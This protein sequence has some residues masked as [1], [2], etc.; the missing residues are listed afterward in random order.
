MA[1][2]PR[3]S[4]LFIYALLIAVPVVS[5]VGAVALNVATSLET[6]W[7]FGLESVRQRPWAA[8]ALTTFGCIVGG[9]LLHRAE[10]RRALYADEPPPPAAPPLPGWVVDRPTEVQRAVSALRR[11]RTRAVGITTALHGAGGFGKTTL[12]D[13]VCLDRRVR[14]RFNQRIYHITIGRDV[15]TRAAIAAKANEIAGFITG[16]T[17][18]YEDPRRAGEH[19]GRLLDQR[20][21]CLLV[22]DDVW[23]EGQL[24]PF[25]IGG[26]ACARLVTTRVPAALPD[27]SLP[28][29]VDQMSAEQAR[30]LL[31]WEMPALHDELADDLLA[32]TGRWPLLLRLINRLL[33]EVGPSATEVNAE[34]ARLLHR[35]LNRGPTAAD[36]DQYTAIDLSA[37]DERNR[38]VGATMRAGTQLLGSGGEIRFAEMGIFAED[39]PIPVDLI[40]RLWEA[41]GGLGR[42]EGRRLC[43]RLVR[44][45]LAS[46][47]EDGT[48]LILHDVIRDYLRA[49]L[50][51]AGLVDCNRA[52]VDSLAQE[53]PPCGPLAEGHPHPSRAWWELAE[54]HDYLPGHLVAHLSAAGRAAEAEAVAGDLRWAETRLLRF[55]P[56][57]VYGDLARIPGERAGVMAAA[58]ARAAH[59]FTPT[60]PTYAVIDALHARL[61]HT[62]GWDVQV[63]ARRAG[64]TR[65][66]LSSRWPLTDVPTGSLR[67]TLSGHRAPVCSVAVAPDGSWLATAGYD[68][69]VTWDTTTGRRRRQFLGHEDAVRAVV[70]SP[71]G[72]LLATASGENVRLW[73]PGT[74]VQRRML[75]G[76]NTVQTLAFSPDSAWLV[77][78]G[79]GRGVRLWEAG[80][81]RRLRTFTGP[82]ATVRSVV[83]APDGTWLAAGDDDGAVWVWDTDTSEPRVRIT[84]A[85]RGPV[86][87]VAISPDGAWLVSGGDDGAV[88]SW[89]ARTGQPQRIFGRQSSPVYA[90]AFSGEGNWLAA[91]GRSAEVRLWQWPGGETR[92]VLS[93]HQHPVRALAADPAGAWLASGGDDKVVHLWNTFATPDS[94]ISEHQAERV[95]AVSVQDGGALIVTAGNGGVVRRWDAV[96]GVPRPGGAAGF[97]APAPDDD[98]LNFSGIDRRRPEPRHL[99]LR[100]AT[101][102]PNGEWAAGAE[103]GNGQVR[104]WDSN[105][106]RQRAELHDSRKVRLLRI[107]PD[108]AWIAGASHDSTVRQWHSATGHRTRALT[109]HTGAVTALAIA[110][111]GTWFASGAQDATVRLWDADTGQS[112]AVVTGHTAA[113]TAL[114]IAPD[115]TWFA[116][117]ASD[118]SVHRWDARTGVL[119]GGLTRRTQGVTAL[120]VSSDGAWV[121]TATK[122]HVLRIWDGVTGECAALIRTG[123]PLTALTWFPRSLGLAVGGECGLFALDFRPGTLRPL[124]AP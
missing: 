16:Q 93:G 87:S 74:G 11:G 100:V 18:A 53:L 97:P 13:L 40:S 105:T 123:G 117:G 92:T 58:V 54:H 56:S 114:A 110:P 83:F 82:R 113:V 7:P 38:A 116:S 3:G 28:V 71:D 49:E 76:H 70:I 39:E 23:S 73:D 78:A 69:V 48:T 51:E 103:T 96:T 50:G 36:R 106:G 89:N 5:V 10:Q 55:G 8:V 62:P 91:A 46:R 98:W 115:G 108:G 19:L 90:L 20:P 121:A 29:V 75:P 27:G 119:L 41:T 43:T 109:G 47:S 81:G 86:G 26:R 79:Q 68:K 12:A 60:D 124:P 34:A 45:S 24:A 84:A 94:S 99:S 1:L 22:I 120:A 57:A 42:A 63:S 107:A 35:L 21:R 2:R 32:V 64:L 9:V 25:L 33:H 104:L 122:D 61:G 15:R 67:R 52:L 31:T 80:T 37:P 101:F 65:P 14:R 77:D 102:A 111:D 88:R 112:Q 4:T 118:G 59:L 17:P 6:T 44:L 30:Q 85:H 95:S 66:V 72:T